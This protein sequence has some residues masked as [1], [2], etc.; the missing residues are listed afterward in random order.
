MALAVVERQTD[1]PD[2][3]A[4]IARSA[5]VAESRPESKATV[6]TGCPRLLLQR[7]GAAEQFASC[8]AGLGLA[9]WRVAALLRRLAGIGLFG[10]RCAGVPRGCRRQTPVRAGRAL[11]SGAAPERASTLQR[12]RTSCGNAVILL[13]QPAPESSTRSPRDPAAGD[14]FGSSWVPLRRRTLICYHRDPVQ[15]PRE[16]GTLG[17][18]IGK[19]RARR[20]EC[21]RNDCACC[22]SDLDRF[23]SQVFS[24]F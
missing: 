8:V 3:P 22:G 9:G 18:R 7:W 23:D 17:T 2:A 12:E 15:P 21:G 4:S 10:P 5:A 6:V 16:I 11:G 14:P 20:P 19:T 24:G 1:H 13:T